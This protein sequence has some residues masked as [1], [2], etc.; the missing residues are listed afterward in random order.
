MFKVGELVRVIPD[1]VV[2]KSVA[3][4]VVRPMLNYAGKVCKIESRYNFGKQNIYSV[5]FGGKISGFFLYEGTLIR[6][7]ATL[8]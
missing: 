4:N 8:R 6:N 3:V 2:G 1:I 7:T 5:S